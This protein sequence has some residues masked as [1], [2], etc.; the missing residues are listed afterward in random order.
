VKEKHKPKVRNHVAC[1]GR[2]CV[3]PSD[4]FAERVEGLTG[5]ASLRCRASVGVGFR[6]SSST[7]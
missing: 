7:F 4:Q 2:G 5:E 6:T 3:A 1:A